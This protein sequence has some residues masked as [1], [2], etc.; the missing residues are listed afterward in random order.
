MLSRNI[1]VDRTKQL[2][3]DIPGITAHGF[4]SSFS[5]WVTETTTFEAD[6]REVALAHQVGDKVAQAYQRGAMLAKRRTMME[7]WAAYCQGKGID[8]KFRS[9]FIVVAA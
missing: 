5:T 7:T 4:R 6:M 1:F 9:E 3:P 8:R 2:M